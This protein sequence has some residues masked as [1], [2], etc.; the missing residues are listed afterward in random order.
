MDGTP[1]QQGILRTAAGWLMLVV[2]LT[3][4]EPR[5]YGYADPGSGLL[6][7]QMLGAMV[8]GSLFYVRRFFRWLAFLRKSSKHETAPRPSQEQ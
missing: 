4:A 3:A 6:L 5:A 8:V 2:I 7:W 1:E